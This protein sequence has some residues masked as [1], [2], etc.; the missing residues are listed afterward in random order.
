MMPQIQLMQTRCSNSRKQQ[1][2]RDLQT[3]HAPENS[4]LIIKELKNMTNTSNDDDDDD[5]DDDDGIMMMIMILVKMT[6]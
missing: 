6:G 4:L 5:D 2:C 3:I 1:R